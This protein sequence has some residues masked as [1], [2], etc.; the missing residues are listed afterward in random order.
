M[1]ASSRVLGM[2]GR[3]SSCSFFF[4]VFFLFFFTFPVNFSC[5][6]GNHSMSHSL[7]KIQNKK[8]VLLLLTLP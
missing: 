7:A 1:I 8:N 2:H 5:D 4:S 3:R 6:T